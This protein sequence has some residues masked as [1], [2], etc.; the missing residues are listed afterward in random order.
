[1]NNISELIRG[2][3]TLRLQGVADEVSVGFL[4][5]AWAKRF[6]SILAV[7]SSWAFLLSLYPSTTVHGELVSLGYAVNVISMPLM[8]IAFAMLRRS[9]RRVNSLPDEMLD[10]RQVQDR[11]WAYKMG[12]LVV[13]RIGL[14]LAILG[15]LASLV[16]WYNQGAT[17]YA[18]DTDFG[19]SNLGHTIVFIQT[20]IEQFFFRNGITSSFQLLGLL[21]Y[22]AYSFPLILLAWR[23]ARYIDLDSIR[24]LE[25][26]NYQAMARGAAKRYFQ[27]L[28]WLGY[29]LLLTASLLT[30]V[31]LFSGVGG[32]L[33]FYVFF[34]SIFYG[35]WVYGFGMFNQAFLI[36]LI[37]DSALPAPASTVGQ[38]LYGKFV[39]SSII[40]IVML[41]LFLMVI[42]PTFWV[43]GSWVMPCFFAGGIA[44]LT[45]HMN[46]FFQIAEL[47]KAPTDDEE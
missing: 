21:T 40:G 36:R 4:E 27:R 38:S 30:S 29:A 45:L 25:V 16:V 3:K 32:P 2:L 42:N 24:A 11:D 14:T 13:R 12:Y 20:F 8:A 1:M 23:E 10:E 19:T 28:R 33:F 26:A 22:V 18:F 17:A 35:V 15:A 47:G 31:N 6:A 9:A 34:G 37:R 46:A 41:V 43:L 5:R 39:A 44:L 7:A